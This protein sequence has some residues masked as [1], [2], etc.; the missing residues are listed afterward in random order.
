M[1]E[2]SLG[3]QEVADPED[4]RFKNAWEALWVGVLESSLLEAWL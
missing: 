2:T 1:L 3:G 4:K